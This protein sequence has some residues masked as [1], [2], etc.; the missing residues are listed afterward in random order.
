M[1]KQQK[2]YILGVVV[3]I[4]W[5]IVGYQIFSYAN[6][7]SEEI[8]EID[9][10]KFRPKENKEKELYTVS[11]H[12]RDPFLDTYKA[13]PK[14]KKGNYKPKPKTT[15]AFPNIVYNG[16]VA[17][18]NTKSFIVTINGAQQIMN[19]GGV[20]N[21]VKLL[22]GTLSKIKIRYKGVTKTIVK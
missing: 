20:A 3:V 13:P 8:A 7:E 14:K 6:P 15:I 18:G 16:M 19:R 17:N 9:Y 4:V 10:Q 5:G 11:V 22:S 21:E 1:K 2:T 12:E